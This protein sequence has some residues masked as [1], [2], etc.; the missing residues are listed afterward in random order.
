MKTN[1]FHDIEMNH[2]TI[3][4]E[5]FLFVQKIG[6]DELMIYLHEWGAN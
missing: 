4:Q 5:V 2:S 6:D 3:K 1:S